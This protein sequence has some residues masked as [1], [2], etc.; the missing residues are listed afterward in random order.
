MEILLLEAD[1]QLVM[2][3]AHAEVDG[4]LAQIRLTAGLDVKLPGRLLC[5]NGCLSRLLCGRRSFWVRQLG[6]GVAVVSGG[7]G[8]LGRITLRNGRKRG[9]QAPGQ[10]PA[11]EY[12]VLP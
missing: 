11:D 5:R 7:V 9:E 4:D 12:S 1:N 6:H 3:V 2:V 10:Q 8:G